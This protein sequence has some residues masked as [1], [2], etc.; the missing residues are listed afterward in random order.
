MENLEVGLVWL[1]DEARGAGFEALQHWLIFVYA[2]SVGGHEAFGDSRMSLIARRAK[3]LA[4]KLEIQG[5]EDAKAWL[6]KYA[7]IGEFYDDIGRKFWETI[8]YV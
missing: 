4:K 1:S 2:I 3:V 7:W 8:A 6:C 5:W